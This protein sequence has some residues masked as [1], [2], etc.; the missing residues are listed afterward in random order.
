MKPLARSKKF[1]VAIGGWG[2]RHEWG[3]LPGRLTSIFGLVIEFKNSRGKEGF[4]FIKT[5][6]IQSVPDLYYF[7]LA[8]NVPVNKPPAISSVPDQT[9]SSFTVPL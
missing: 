8:L 9:P 2:N 7:L 1:I 3:G 4:Q 5:W 6:K